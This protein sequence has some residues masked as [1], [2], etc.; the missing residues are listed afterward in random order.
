MDIVDKA[1]IFA[2][3]AYSAV[4]RPWQCQQQVAVD[5]LMDKGASDAVLAATWLGRVVSETEV[6]YQVIASEFGM[7]IARLVERMNARFQLHDARFEDDEAVEQQVNTIAAAQV[8]A[9]S[10]RM[11][12]Q[13]I[14]NNGGKDER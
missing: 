4:G 6:T 10:K 13:L 14:V 9:D 7:E 2:I 12:L 11:A 3:A 8:G 5:Y 1:R